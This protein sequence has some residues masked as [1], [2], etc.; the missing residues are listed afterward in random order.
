MSERQHLDP[1]D[2]D[3]VR[4]AVGLDRGDSPL[5]DVGLARIV[6]GPDALDALPELAA[7]ALAATDAAKPLIAVIVDGHPMARGDADLTA[8][9]SERLAAVGEVRIVRLAEPDV[10]L[11]ADASAIASAVDG[12]RG[13]ACLAALGSGT[14]CDIVKEASRELDIPDLAWFAGIWTPELVRASIDEAAAIAAGA[15]AP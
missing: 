10:E 14:I 13:A 2:L 11:H 6:I 8:R 4:A 9:V 1:T 5:H 7:A 15:I 12:A 3:A